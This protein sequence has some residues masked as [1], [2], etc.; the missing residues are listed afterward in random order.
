MPTKANHPFAL[1]AV[2][3]PMPEPLTYA[4]PG[5]LRGRLGVGMRVLVPLGGAG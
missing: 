4:V 1:V 3:A 2:P 5:G